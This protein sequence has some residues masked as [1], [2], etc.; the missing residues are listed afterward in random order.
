MGVKSV[1]LRDFRT[2]WLTGLLLALLCGCTAEQRTSQESMEPTG[3]GIDQ[4]IQLPGTQQSPAGKSVAALR[5]NAEAAMEVEEPV[6]VPPVF[7]DVAPLLGVDFEWYADRVPGRFFLPEVMGGGIGWLDVDGDG[8]QDLY[9]ANGCSLAGEETGQ[10][11]GLFRNLRGKRFEGVAVTAAA[12]DEGYGQGV[13]IG[14]WNVDGFPDICVANYGLNRLYLN[15]GDGTY[16]EVSESWGMEDPGWS[17]SGLC[18]DLN[19]DG[20]PDLYNVNY[21]DVTLANNRV[22]TYGDRMG[23][24]GPGQYESVADSIWINSGEGTFQPAAAELGFAVTASS[25]LAISAAD[26]D[27]DLSPEIYVAN[28]MQANLM[29]TRSTAG[30]RS[31]LW[32]EIARVS[33]VAVA[34]DGMNEASMGIATADFD[35]DGLPDLYLT[36]YYQMKNTLY[37]NL[38]GLLFEDDSLR[39]GVAASSLP[40]LGFGTVAFDYNAD[41]FSDVFVANGHVLGPQVDPWTMSAQLLQNNNGRFRDVSASAGAYF[42]DA[43]IGRGTASGDIDND[44]DTDVTVSHIDRPISI[45]R[46][47]TLESPVFLSISLRSDDRC[48]SVGARVRVISGETILEQSQTGAGSYLSTNDSRLIFHPQQKVVLVEVDWPGGE[49]RR[50]PDCPTGGTVILQPQGRMWEVPQ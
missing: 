24:C 33:G 9:F 41:G 37:R 18:L 43:W 46:N 35:R 20:L 42:L 40:L 7:I 13:T 8:W 4:S 50:Y 32:D 12:A 5:I 39:T 16:V 22:C 36:H 27:G 11:N 1:R 47:D 21:M 3:S 49:T 23:Y 34:A 29:F 6:G 38:G 25:G 14:D 2:A 44:G 15:Q 30:E 48:P 10:R 45:L 17:T 31:V 19:A 28:D 26:L